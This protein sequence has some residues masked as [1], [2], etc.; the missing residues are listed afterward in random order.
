MNTARASSAGAHTATG[1]IRLTYDGYGLTLRYNIH[2]AIDETSIELD[3]T[4]LRDASDRLKFFNSQ[5][6]FDRSGSMTYSYITL[7]VGTE[8]E[9][10]SAP[11]SPASMEEWLR[12][13]HH[14]HMKYT[15]TLWTRNWD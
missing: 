9:E 1:E 10:G 7:K 15:F 8:G 5:I 12:Q 4:Y 13:I 3:D 2:A 6:T 14:I 11:W